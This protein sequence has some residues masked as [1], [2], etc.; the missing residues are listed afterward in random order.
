MKNVIYSDQTDNPLM[1]QRWH[2]S[3][4]V[5]I[6][7]IEYVRNGMIEQIGQTSPNRKK[8][9]IG[10]NHVIDCLEVLVDEIREALESQGAL[11]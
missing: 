7:H 10:I 3:L 6:R 11:R 5:Q 4:I 9:L 2:D 1:L 8:M